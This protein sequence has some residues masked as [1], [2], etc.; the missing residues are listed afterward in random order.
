MSATSTYEIH[1]RSPKHGHPWPSPPASPRRLVVKTSRPHVTFVEAPSPKTGY[2]FR[3]Y[4]HSN[5]IDKSFVYP[6][7]SSS[8]LL[9]KKSSTF[10]S[11][12]TAI[13]FAN[14]IVPP[15]RSGSPEFTRSH[16]VAPILEKLSSQNLNSSG[17]ANTPT[18]APTTPLPHVETTPDALNAP[19]S[20]PPP[21]SQSS[22]PRPL[23]SPVSMDTPFSIA[24]FF[25]FVH[26]SGKHGA[27]AAAHHR[28]KP[29]VDSF[30]AAE[31]PSPTS[32]EQPSSPVQQSSRTL[33]N[34]ILAN[35]I[36]STTLHRARSSSV[37][38]PPQPARPSSPESP[39]LPAHSRITPVNFRVPP[40]LRNECSGIS[41]RK[42]SSS[43]APT[44]SPVE[45]RPTT[46]RR[47]SFATPRSPNFKNRV[48]IVPKEWESYSRQFVGNENALS[49]SEERPAWLKKLEES[50]KAD[51]EREGERQRAASPARSASPTRPVA[52]G[53]D[54]ESAYRDR[55]LK[56]AQR[57]RAAKE[58][59]EAL[60]RERKVEE[61]GTAKARRPSRRTD[62][63]LPEIVIPQ[64][65]ADSQDVG[66]ASVAPTP[67]TPDLA[68]DPPK[69]DAE[70]GQ[71][72][73]GRESKRS[74]DREKVPRPPSKEKLGPEPLEVPHGPTTSP[75]L[76]MNMPSPTVPDVTGGHG[77]AHVDEKVEVAAARTASPDSEDAERRHRRHEPRKGKTVE[78]WLAET[79]GVEFEDDVKRPASPEEVKEPRP[80]RTL[81]HTQKSRVGLSAL[82]HSSQHNLN[83][84]KEEHKLRD[85]NSADKPKQHRHRDR[86][87]PVQ[88]DTT[89]VEKVCP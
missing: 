43:S 7:L 60:K 86:Q 15:L 51:E 18:H 62:K 8:K 39:F 33:H 74:R 69:V 27:T 57:Q 75:P 32:P 13:D 50:K 88:A 73:L 79:R 1:D 66:A 11:L 54:E 3:S 72:D 19:A 44:T 76:H 46:G 49:D 56:E 28:S 85:A 6:G 87:P 55:K 83:I 65:P 52:M 64:G 45:P 21:V 78:S 34:P 71:A 9:K 22:F 4:T 63:D 84:T 16:K 70:V 26:K 38:A 29:T 40:A 80:P 25:E 53:A 10:P 12:H 20:A 61:R 48:G 17:P 23:N 37:D 35:V 81:R 67:M 59:E 47:G 58:A 41:L 82:H 31:P 89:L 2:G 24:E 5:G 36:K 42:L 30:Q 77:N 14:D 68:R